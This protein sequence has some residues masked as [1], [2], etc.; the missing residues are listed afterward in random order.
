MCEGHEVSKQAVLDAVEAKWKTI[1]GLRSTSQGWPEPVPDSALPMAIIDID[2]E[3]SQPIGF[4]AGGTGQLQENYTVKMTLLLGK[5]DM[6]RK[7]A[8][9]T[10]VPMLNRVLLAF[11]ADR[12]LGGAADFTKLGNCSTNR[13]TYHE[14]KEYPLMEWALE[15][16]AYTRANATPE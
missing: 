8:L 1:S 4:D 11:S 15:V 12:F 2:T 7:T 6:R 3:S 9:R 13:K 5:K 16:E 14:N 10:S